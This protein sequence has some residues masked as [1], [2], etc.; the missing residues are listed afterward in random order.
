M[1]LCSLQTVLFTACSS[2]F[3]SA[4]SQSRRSDVYAPFT[5][6]TRKTKEQRSQTICF[7][8]N[9]KLQQVIDFWLLSS[10][11]CVVWLEGKPAISLHF[12]QSCHSFLMS[13]TF[14][15][16]SGYL[17]L[18]RTNNENESMMW[19]ACWFAY[20]HWFSHPLCSLE[21][22]RTYM[23]VPPPGLNQSSPFLWLLLLGFIKSRR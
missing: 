7:H 1:G 21:A 3:C 2:S 23:R 20:C 6:I 8:N 17:N 22:D 16:C 15:V 19:W 12:Y 14:F 5:F 18:V 13:K 10:W 11:W 9:H 4:P